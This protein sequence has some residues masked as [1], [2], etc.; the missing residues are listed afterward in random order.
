MQNVFN[1]FT[2]AIAERPNTNSFKLTHQ[3]KTTF[4]MGQLIPT[5]H[6][7]VVPGDNFYRISPEHVARLAEM[8][9]PVM[10]NV[11]VLFEA[12]FVPYRILWPDW[13]DF[14]TGKDASLV[15]PYLQN[16]DAGGNFCTD[17]S[18]SDYFGVPFGIHGPIPFSAFRFAAYRKIWYDWY[19][20]QNLQNPDEDPQY[21]FQDL[22]DGKVNNHYGPSVA[23]A[24]PYYRSYR[25]DYFTGSLP[26]AQKGTAISLPLITDPDGELD[27]EF[28]TTMPG[29]PWTAHNTSGTL[30]NP[31]GNEIVQ[32]NTSGGVES[33]GTGFTPLT[34]DPKGNL[35]VKINDNAVLINDLREA[36][37]MQEILELDA[38][39]GTRYVEM[40]RAHFGVR[41]KDAR[42]Q[43]PEFLGRSVSNV[44]QSRSRHR[45]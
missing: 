22:Q 32:V 42:H 3:H 38:V 36:I 43:R 34:F 41:S 35:V 8:L 31:V 29:Q 10:H 20:D 15:P 40:L 30:L 7:E 13:E 1:Q 25:A 18:L 44:S 6:L 24:A 2:T 39:A 28:P 45:P 26:F 27:V 4:K 16:N 12:F 21:A 37:K 11:K 14:I 17:G 33:M 5:L 23:G 9:A 19:R